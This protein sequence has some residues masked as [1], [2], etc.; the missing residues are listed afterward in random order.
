MK[1]VIG[2][3]RIQNI[4]MIAGLISILLGL[5]KLNIYTG[6]LYGLY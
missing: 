6:I 5:E 4:I 2:D 3:K 1:E